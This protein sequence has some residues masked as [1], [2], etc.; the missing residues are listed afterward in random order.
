MYTYIAYIHLFLYSDWTDKIYK[1]NI[2]INAITYLLYV[3]IYLLYIQI[4]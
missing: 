2:Q 1:I 3:S 4:Y